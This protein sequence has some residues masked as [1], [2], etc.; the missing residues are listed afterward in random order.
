ME[1]VVI[2][3]KLLVH[4]FYYQGYNFIFYSRIMA[5]EQYCYYLQLVNTIHVFRS[6]IT[7]KPILRR[8]LISV[9]DDHKEH[10]FSNSFRVEFSPVALMRP[11]RL[12][13]GIGGDRNISKFPRVCQIK[14]PLK[15]FQRLT[16]K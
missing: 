3:F 4:K 10:Y 12:L 13:G 8:D 1:I 6:L 14:H 5:Y 16:T 9:V 11:G 2:N 15:I 7:K